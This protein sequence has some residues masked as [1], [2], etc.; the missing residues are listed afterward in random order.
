MNHTLIAL[1]ALALAACKGDKSTSD[2]GSSDAEN[3]CAATVSSSV[4]ADGAA[5][6][7]YRADVEF[8]ISE[9]DASATVTV[10]DSSGAAVAGTQSTSSDGLTVYFT[11]DASL[12]PGASY[13]ADISLCDGETN[14]SITFSTS[15]L[16]EAL[17]GCELTGNTY[18]L[19]LGDA[20]FVQP[21][22]VAG[23]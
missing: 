3:S 22:G 10:L 20:R 18:N 12:T 7:Y 14:P 9:M 4:P 15:T 19:N 2:S 11:P 6:A 16:G 8:A 17:S 23:P 13:T 5:D 21:A 1:S